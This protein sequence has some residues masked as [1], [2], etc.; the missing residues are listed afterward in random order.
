MTHPTFSR[1]APTGSSYSTAV[2]A[3]GGR[4]LFV[5]GQLAIRPDGSAITQDSMEAQATQVFENLKAICEECGASLRNVVKMNY[6]C[7]DLSRFGEVRAVRERYLSPP[8][9]ASTAVGVTALVGSFLLEV[10][11]VVELPRRESGR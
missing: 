8:H 4:L 10:E 6:Y 3:D 1:V 5:S 11:M 2:Q 7:T 9:P